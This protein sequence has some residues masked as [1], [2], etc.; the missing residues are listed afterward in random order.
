MINAS[1]CFIVEIG[2]FEGMESPKLELLKVLYL[3]K[4]ECN[5]TRNLCLFKIKL[6]LNNPPK[7]HSMNKRTKIWNLFILQSFVSSVDWGN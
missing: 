1:T 2:I 5:S 7:H 6:I 3:S 4:S